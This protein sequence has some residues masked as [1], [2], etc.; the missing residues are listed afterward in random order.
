[1]SLYIEDKQNALFFEICL[2]LHWSLLLHLAFLQLQRVG[3][4]LQLCADFSLWLLLL[5][6]T[7][8]VAVR[9]VLGRLSEC[10]ILP[11]QGSNP[12]PLHWQADS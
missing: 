8:L 7:G 3:A 12:C 1:M 9:P 6:S 5:H 4:T 2:R 10:G 11:D